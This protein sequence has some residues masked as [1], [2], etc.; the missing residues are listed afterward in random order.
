MNLLG[1]CF[2][3]LAVIVVSDFL[4]YQYLYTRIASLIAS[5]LSRPRGAAILVHSLQFMSRK[6]LVRDVFDAFAALTVV[7]LRYSAVFFFW[8]FF[9]V[10]F[11]SFFLLM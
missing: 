2:R 3:T 7:F 8:S 4:F 6:S 9:L 11:S 10:F 1:S 5:N